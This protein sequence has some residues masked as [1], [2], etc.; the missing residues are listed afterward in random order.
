MRP[1]GPFNADPGGPADFLAPTMATLSLP[2]LVS[3]L[4]V[5]AALLGGAALVAQ[6]ATSV[7]SAHRA[8]ASPAGPAF[9]ISG[10]LNGSL[11]PGAVMPVRLVVRNPN[12]FAI[13]ITR[14]RTVASIDAEH[15][16][17]GCV[18]RTNFFVRP[19]ARRWRTLR[20]RAHTRTRLAALRTRAPQIGMRN[21]QTNQDACKGAHLKL[22]YSGRAVRA[23]KR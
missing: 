2:R 7:G 4:L 18:V 10:D 17:P 20:L 8:T 1:Q 19:G 14:L 5:G 9:R 21:L 15:A 13:V 3:L 11:H 12:P 23:R 16:N 22:R 6:A